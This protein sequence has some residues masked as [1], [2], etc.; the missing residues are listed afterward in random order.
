MFGA[1]GAAI[2]HGQL[3]ASNL[4]QMVEVP[5]RGHA[6]HARRLRDGRRGEA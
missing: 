1:A 6:A 3:D 4:A 2:A 5:A